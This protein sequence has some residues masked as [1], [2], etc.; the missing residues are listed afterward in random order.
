MV[1]LNKEDFDFLNQFYPGLKA[2]TLKGKS[3]L[4]GRIAFSGLY[5]SAKG[6]FILSPDR[7]HA[8]DNL[9]FI[10]DEYE[11]LIEFPPAEL[12]LV[13]EI[14]ARQKAM[15]E[16]KRW[17]DAR[18]LHVKNGGSICL[19]ARPL[20]KI[21]FP[22][23]APFSVF[24]HNLVLPYF[25]GLSYFEKN[26]SWPWGEY[27]HGDV[28]TFEYYWE[29]KTS[30]TREALQACVGSLGTKGREALRL[31][32]KGH[33]PCL[34]GSKKIYRKCHKDVISIIQ[35]FNNDCRRFSIKIIEGK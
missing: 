30:L 7:S 4:I 17:K 35:S 8:E 20:E 32:L 18:I 31:D 24:M 6:V 2:C 9:N 11:I 25:Y 5:D 14:G 19:C 27:G 26:G 1:P 16:E 15:M 3:V 29:L 12:P 22:S 13:Y 33:W 34:C 28:G 23:G 21:K 10:V